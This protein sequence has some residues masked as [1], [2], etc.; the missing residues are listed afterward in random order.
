[1]SGNAPRRPGEAGRLLHLKGWLV[2]VLLL[3]VW[4]Y[5]AGLSQAHAHAFV[6]LQ[7]VVE[8]ARQLILSGELWLNLLGSLQRTSTGLVIGS[9]AGLA[10][11]ILLAFSRIAL[12]LVSPLFHSIRQVPLLGLTPLIALWMGNGEPAKIFLVS[13]AAFYPLVLN[14]YEGL[15]NVD[16]QYQ[17]L[18]RILGFNRLLLFRRVLLPAAL[19]SIFTGLQQAVP[20]AWITALGSELLFNA[21]TGLG[22]LM[23][24]AEVG[25]R[26]DI[27]I[28]CAVTVT[29]LGMLMSYLVGALANRVLNRGTVKTG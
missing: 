4:Q 27:I 19:P 6:P 25:A 26:M 15:R 7:Q 17:E 29:L 2:P 14:T 3:A 8:A 13:L 10:L 24:T 18:G 20:F 1:M 12:T 21:G 9:L 28:V 16:P 11:G 22:S 23:M 5:M